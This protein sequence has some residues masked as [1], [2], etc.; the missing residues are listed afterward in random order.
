MKANG[1]QTKALVLEVV[2]ETLGKESL[3]GLHDCLDERCR[4]Q[5]AREDVNEELGRVALRIGNEEVVAV[6]GGDQLPKKQ[7]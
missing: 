2:N 1:V 5:I 3:K 6:G 7:S 4:Y